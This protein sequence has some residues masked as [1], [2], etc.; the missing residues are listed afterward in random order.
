MRKYEVYGTK[1]NWF[2]SDCVTR[3]MGVNCGVTMNDG[4][5]VFNVVQPSNDYV[6]AELPVVG[7]IEI[8]TQEVEA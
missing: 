1:D 7:H 2:F 4:S 8:K 3:A 5:F 6:K